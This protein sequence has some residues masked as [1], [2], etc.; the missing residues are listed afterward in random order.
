MS[1]YKLSKQGTPSLEKTQPQC[2]SRRDFLLAGAS[3]VI[4]T[5]I[6]SFSHSVEAL[7]KGY[8]RK[9]VANV[10]SL[11]NGACLS[12]EYPENT[13]YSTNNLYKL[14]VEAGRGVGPKKDIVAFNG[15]CTHMGGPLTGSYNEEHKVAGPCPLHLTTFDLTR[16]GM[17][18]SGH[19][20][21]S[22]PQ[23]M[24]EVEGD[25]IFAI[26]MLGLIYGLNDN[27]IGAINI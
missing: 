16:H 2:W 10:S 8:P 18:V 21:Q 3:T 25:E 14:N 27:L 23:V 24:L 17:V 6:P 15:F 1:S 22:L 26:G 11:A 19:A 5:S 12:F 13:P 20:T 4:L 7:V 9:K